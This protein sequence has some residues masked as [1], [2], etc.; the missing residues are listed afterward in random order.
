MTSPVQL[1]GPITPPVQIASPLKQRSIGFTDEQDSKLV[2]L[3]AA[4]DRSVGWI[5]RKLVDDAVHPDAVSPPA[6]ESASR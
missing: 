1:A 5:V 4:Q 2:A 3:A 6:L